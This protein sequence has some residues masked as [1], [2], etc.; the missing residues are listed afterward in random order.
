MTD[1]AYMPYFQDH[2]HDLKYPLA[3]SGLPGL[4]NAQIGAI[5]SIASH[6]TL[7]KDPAII[8]L[9]T[10]SGK[11]AVLMMSAFLLRANRVLVITPSRMVRDQIREDFEGL[12]TL[13][14][15]GAIPE[16]MPLPNV[17]EAESKITSADGWEQ[18]RGYDVVISTPNC[19][20]P[21]IEEIADPPTD[22][23]DLLLI[24]E[25]HHSAAKTWNDLLK[26]FPSAKKILF[27]AT[28]FRRDRREIEGRFVYN[29]PIVKSFEDGIFGK[30]RYIPVN[31]ANEQIDNDVAIAK[32][33]EE[34][35]K[36]DREANF[37]H[38]LMVR[39]DSRKR[40]DD[41]A[42]IYKN[43][44]QLKLEVI[45]SGHSYARVKKAVNKLKS[46]E[47]DG[48]I[49]VNMLGEGFNFP[50]LKIAA[51][52][53][54]HKSL[55]ITLQFV[56]RFAR[57]NAAGIGEA[58]FLAV[59]SELEIEGERLFEEGAVWQEAIIGLSHLRIETEQE[60]RE[61]LDQFTNPTASEVDVEDL[62]LYS[63]N[64]R[65]HVKIFKVSET[66]N[67]EAEIPIKGAYEIVY[68]N[69][70]EDNSAIV[71][72]T[73]EMTKPKWATSDQFVSLQYDLFVI[74][75]DKEHQ[76]LFVN[77]SRSINTLYQEIAKSID[78]IARPLPTSQIYKAFS[79]LV[80]ASFF[81]IGM[82]NRVMG[83]SVES[84]RII[85]GSS[86]QGS[87][88]KSDGRLYRQ[89]HAFCTAE[90]NEGEKITLGYSSASKIWS[91]SSSQIPELIKWCH[92]L[93][94]K[95]TSTRAGKT[96][97]SLDFLD[98]GK[99]VSEIPEGIIAG[100]WT[101]DAYDFSNP[102]QARYQGNQGRSVTCHITDLELS[103]D[104]GNTDSQKIRLLVTGEA[105]SSAFNFS[106][107]SFFE[108]A[109]GDG[110][111]I[112]ILRGD[113]D[114]ISLLDY[115]NEHYLCFY[116]TDF[117][118]LSGNELFAA[119]EGE[120][121]FDVRQIESVDWNGMDIQNECSANTSA[122]VS[123]HDFLKQRVLQD[124]TS[125]IVFYDHGSG[126]LADYLVVTKTDDQ[127]LFQLYHC[128]GSGG[129]SAGSRVDDMY[130]VC[131]QAAKSVRW[132][133][134]RRLNSKV[135]ARN[136]NHK[137]LRG[138]MQIFKETIEAAK[139][140]PSKFEII[141]VQPGLSGTAVSDSVS[142]VL[143]AVS[144]SLVANGCEPLKVLA[145]R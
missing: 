142:E 72:I 77:S 101:N 49:C 67:M 31:E 29:Y 84:Y 53:S 78:P 54:P 133:H 106:I 43:N 56:G 96:N 71:L 143:A 69:N 129:P 123:V 73:K 51:I 39:T 76:L 118:M 131:G 57:T 140:I 7:R 81:N 36:E 12:K 127:I 60:T 64:P 141:I 135:I 119:V 120:S 90:D 70:N 38:S 144:D 75:L 20:S 86:A 132:A 5:H 61:A 104:H 107:D 74:Y 80:N 21:A 28:P 68:R 34:V 110:Q 44:T 99:V 59:P 124:T 15:I 113:A 108:A 116:T 89:G 45:H 30:I 9:P 41:L 98:A 103:I 58:K 63:L 48:I 121:S 3:G 126:E 24:D 1:L 62:S 114:P 10:G 125:Q 97:S 100:D 87:I 18:L 35:L 25:A 83:S 14:E 2:Y 85:A 122:G 4:Y 139:R 17:F 130:E 88:K 50:N 115:L 23:F 19:V 66:V 112:T 109:D 65:Q 32:R 128:K 33:A 95:L 55:E 42:T 82:R 134:P 102:L 93:A 46:H 91:S 92:A 137:F 16:D 47:L 52:H 105:V 117:S 136:K 27:T 22:L 8:T 94:G 79:D 13:K 11:T 40:A 26:T 145:S 138:S 111:E 37:E 6:F